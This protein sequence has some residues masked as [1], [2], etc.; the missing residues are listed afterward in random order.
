[1]SAARLCLLRRLTLGRG[2]DVES[3][4]HAH[5]IAT[6]HDVDGGPRSIL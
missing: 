2:C 1:M 3:Y 6:L 5:K 4:A